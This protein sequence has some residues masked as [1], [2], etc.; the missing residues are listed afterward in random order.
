MKPIKYYLK[1]KNHTPPSIYNKVSVNRIS[2]LFMKNN[3]TIANSLVVAK[4][5]QVFFDD[6]ATLNPKRTDFIAIAKRAQM[7]WQ[8]WFVLHNSI[9]V[10]INNRF[11]ALMHFDQIAHRKSYKKVYL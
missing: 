4:S 1:N 3:T 11:D 10:A 5:A 7:P 9:H 6:V 2:D 8:P